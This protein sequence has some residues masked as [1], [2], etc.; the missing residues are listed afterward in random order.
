MT[1]QE[2]FSIVDSAI[3]VATLSRDQHVRA[4]QAAQWMLREIER[5]TP[6]PEP[7]KESDDE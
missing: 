4:A 5:L 3:A 6:K 1:P 2:A 7:P